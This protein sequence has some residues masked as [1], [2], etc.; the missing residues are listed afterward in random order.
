MKPAWDKLMAEFEDS[1]HALI[2]DVDCTADGRSLCE[3]VSVRGYPT[4]KHGDPNNLQDYEGA[5][6]FD[7]L[8]TFA[9]G[10]L[11]P[12]CGPANL[13]LCDDDSKAKILEFQTMSPADLDAAINEK[14]EAMEK[15]ET[16]F[17]TL[18]EGLQ[19]QYAEAS[20]EK[21]KAVEDI[22]N[23][24]LGLMMSVKASSGKNEL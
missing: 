19:K 3:D 11:G 23:S 6:D 5:R 7:S 18:V 4:I 22:K 10:N 15:L 14:K 13:D 12:K 24:D 9:Q 17:K 20:D 1:K 2:A 8:K 16:D 21:D